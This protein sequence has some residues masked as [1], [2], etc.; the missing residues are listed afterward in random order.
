MTGEVRHAAP[1]WMVTLINRASFSFAPQM[2]TTE[3]QDDVRMTVPSLSVS[4]IG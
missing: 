4:E 2:S 3:L 1:S